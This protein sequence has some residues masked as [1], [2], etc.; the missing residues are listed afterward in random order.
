MP[1]ATPNV[2][3]ITGA[4]GQVGRAL[5][6]RLAQGGKHPVAIVRRQL[7]LPATRIVVGKLS[8]PDACAALKGA[9]FIVHLAGTLHPGGRNTYSAANVESARAVARAASAG[10]TRRILFLSYLGA[11]TSSSNAY[12][13]AK[14]LAE[15]ALIGSG[16]EVVIF[17]CSHIIGSPDS[18]GPMAVALIAKPSGRAIVLGNGRQIAAPVF[19]GDVTDALLAALERG[20]PGVF[21]LT[22]PERMSL[23]DLVRM[24]NQNADALITHVPA[25]AAR[26]MAYFVPGLPRAMVDVLLR[27]SV[28]DPSSAVETFGMKLTPLS[29]IWR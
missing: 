25:W 19:I 2:V 27:A 7:A 18:P 6:A 17:R 13:S 10:Q 5:L 3:A 26:L 23:D 4:S 28:G 24:L 9:D 12:L 16:K 21:D 22:G 20:L 29:T 1:S 11:S 14:A 15:Q 8:S